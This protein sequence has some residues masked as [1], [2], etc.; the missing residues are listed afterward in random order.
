VV[1]LL[2]ILGWFGTELHDEFFVNQTEMQ[3]HQLRFV[4]QTIPAD[5]KVLMDDDLWVD[6][7]E[8]RGNAPV[9]EHAHSHWK[10]AADPAIR[11]T[12]LDN[13]WQNLDY[14]IMSNQLHHIFELNNEQL[15]LDAYN[16]SQLL[17]R[18]QEGDVSLEVR[19]V[20]KDNPSS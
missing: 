19:Q 13:R 9:Y 20:I 10:I 5:A 4:Q 15:A 18:F 3:I 6:L 16:H 8:P 7:H 14:M 12:I 1:A 11:D 2:G 17:A